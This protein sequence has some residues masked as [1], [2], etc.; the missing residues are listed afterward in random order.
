M[1]DFTKTLNLTML[2]ACAY[3]YIKS[4]SMASWIKQQWL[5]IQAWGSKERLELTGGARVCV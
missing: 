5:R 2:T 3:F 4:F 1:V